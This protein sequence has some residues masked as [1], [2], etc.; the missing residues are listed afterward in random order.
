MSEHENNATDNS[1]DQDD[2]VVDA[3]A[4]EYAGHS[5][6]S[7]GVFAG[8]VCIATVVTLWVGSSELIR[9]SVQI[10]TAIPSGEKRMNVTF[11][12]HH[13]DSMKSFV[14]CAFFSR[15][16][17]ALICTYKKMCPQSLQSVC[18]SPLR[19]TTLSCFARKTPVKS[20]HKLL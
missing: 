8:I 4:L 2:E 18:L 16:Y 9:K 17:A 20:K 3:F 1:D 5:T 11:W 13:I 10:H 14:F 7:P 6:S 12:D 19:D 15:P